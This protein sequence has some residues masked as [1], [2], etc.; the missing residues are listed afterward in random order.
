MVN[1][2]PVHAEIEGDIVTT[3]ELITAQIPKV[4]TDVITH[5]MLL[6][7]RANPNEH[8]VEEITADATPRP[9]YVANVTEANN[10]GNGQTTVHVVKRGYV[11]CKTKSILKQGD[12]VQTDGTSKD[13]EIWAG[14]AGADVGDYVGHLNEGDRKYPITNAAV[15]D[16]VVIYWYGGVAPGDAVV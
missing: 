5:G 11:L 9:V 2:S 16:L 10:A 3:R 13:V 15:D 12:K 4:T 7:R 6:K 1:P 14:A 8:Q